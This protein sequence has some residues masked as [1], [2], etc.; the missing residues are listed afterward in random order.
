MWINN[1]VDEVGSLFV[2]P[3]PLSIEVTGDMIYQSTNN[4]IILNNYTSKLSS[5]STIIWILKN[6]YN[7]ICLEF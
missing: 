2:C 3:F 6:Y 7:V 4:H 1:R 5:P